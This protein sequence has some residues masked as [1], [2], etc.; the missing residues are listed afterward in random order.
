MPIIS[1]IAQI[2][3]VAYASRYFALRYLMTPS[4]QVAPLSPRALDLVTS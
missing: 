3:E 4:A 2:S 1:A